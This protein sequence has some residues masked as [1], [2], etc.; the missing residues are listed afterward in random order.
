MVIAKILFLLLFVSFSSALRATNYYINSTAGKDSNK[1]TSASTS[2]KTILPIAGIRLQPGDSVLFARGQK[3][4]GMLSLVNLKGLDKHPIVI[5]S[6]PFKG[7]K[8]KPILDAGKDL[9][10][11]LIKNSSFIYVNGIEFTGMLPYEKTGTANKVEMRCGILV[12]VTKDEAFE[13]IKLNDVLVHDVYYNP[14]GFTRSAAEIK[15]ANGTQ[16]YGWG[17]RVINNTKTGRL[18]YVKI[19]KAEVYNVDHTGIKATASTNG[20]QQLE[21]A[22]CKVYQT[23]GPGMQFSG[24]KD[25]HIH[26]NTVDHS[27]STADSRNWG[28]GSGL[29]TWGCSNILIEHNRFT[30]ANGPGD[31]AGVHIDYNCNDVVIQY[32]VSA[33]NAGGFCEILGNNYNCAYRYNISI[34]DGHRVKGVNGAFQEGK[35]FW[36]S[37]YQGDQ[38]KN[39]GPYNSYFYNNT[40]YVAANIVPKIAV[41]S[42]ADGVLIANNIF[43]FERAAQ[44][45]AGDQK[46]KE[47]DVDGVPNVVF[48]NNLFLRADN[49]PADIPLKDAAPIMGD[50]LFKNKGGLQVKDYLPANKNLIVN[51]SV[52][53][54]PIP[55]D[56][57]GIRIGLQ[58]EHDILGNPIHGKSDIGAI[59]WSNNKKK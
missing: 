39:A 38:K 2:W 59:E 19:L 53:V 31:S 58:I 4:T 26:H 36:L 5:S 6:Y 40:I 55:N 42:S 29:W 7:N 30:N 28:R 24:I 33:N 18:T 25:G 44:T 37:G 32:N 8:A 49:W 57:I 17:I 46:K 10:A 51:R 13:H 11:L 15:T 47:V 34:N 43:Y 50:P 20:I 1:G 14:T 54:L 45:V 41:S 56:S 16:S 21:I 35:I 27:G 22:E 9:N 52:P 3:F 23:G 48:I 12:E